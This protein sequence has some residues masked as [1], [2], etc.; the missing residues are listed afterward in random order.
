MK[1]I[2]IAFPNETYKIFDKMIGK[3]FV[4][5]SC[6]KFIY[7]NSAYGIVGI[8]IDDAVYKITNFIDVVDY[9]GKLEDVAVFKFEKAD[10]K[11]IVSA[12]QDE[13]MNDNPIRRI[14]KKIEVVNENQVQYKNGE[15]LYNNWVT[16]GLIFYFDD[17]TEL[18][19]EKDIWFSEDIGIERGKNLIDK[20]S[21]TDE[22]SEAWE[23]EIA[24]ETS[25][26]SGRATREAIIFTN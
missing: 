18:S 9:Y 16:R 23:P 2:N 19:F 10:K 13:E 4:K 14:I 17:G 5:F 7:S 24:G 6:N 3:N 15:I 26:Y 21:S 20:F 11:E 12:I 22:F 25:E 8:Y 1:S